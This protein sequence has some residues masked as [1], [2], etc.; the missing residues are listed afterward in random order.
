L[1]YPST[2]DDA[3]WLQES[4]QRP[5]NKKKIISIE[6]AMPTVFW[7]QAE[8]YVIDKLPKCER[9]NSLIFGQN[10]RDALCANLR[11]AEMAS[12]IVIHPEN[13]SPHR[14]QKTFIYPKNFDFQLVP[15]PVS[16]PV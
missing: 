7:S 15:H 5:V 3:F 11:P 10:V 4:E 16:S 14:S 9:F 1:F 6:I 2:D 12:S 13:A 8:I